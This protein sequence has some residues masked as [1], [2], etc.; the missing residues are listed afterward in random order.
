MKRFD[1]VYIYRAIIGVFQAM[2]LG[3]S[4]GFA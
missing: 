4:V 1:A 2:L 3:T